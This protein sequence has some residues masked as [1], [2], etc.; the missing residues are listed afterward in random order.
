MTRDKTPPETPNAK[1]RGPRV[2]AA[3]RASDDAM[4]RS[5]QVV[6]ATKRALARAEGVRVLYLRGKPPSRP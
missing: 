2:V 4:I 5:W 6:Q 3:L 1:R